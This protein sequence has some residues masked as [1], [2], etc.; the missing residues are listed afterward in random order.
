MSKIKVAIIML[1]CF[2]LL[3]QSS[4]I[5]DSKTKLFVNINSPSAV[6]MD[7]DTGRILYNKN[8]E[9]TRPMASLTK[10]MTSIMLVENCKM[11]EMIEVP[12]GAAW[13]GGSTVG[14]KKGDKISAES[15]LYGM[16]LPSGNDCAY[17]VG[18]HIGGSIENYGVMATKKAHEIGAINTNIANPHGLDDPNHYSTAYDMALITRYALKNQYIN[19]TV[20]TK[21]KTVNFG[22]FSKNLN[23]TN[24]LLRTYE[25]ADGV[26]TGFTNGA[27]RCLIA[28]ATKDNARYI[29]VVLGAETTKIRFKDAKTLLE[30]CFNRYEQKDISP[31]L[32]FYI[33]IPVYKGN[34]ATY[35][36]KIQDNMIIP[37]TDEEYEKI[38]IKQELITELKPPMKK[39][40]KI[41]NIYA[42]IGDEKIYEKGIFLEE[43]ITKKTVFDYFIDGIKN[44][45]VPTG[46]TL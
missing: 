18:E 21:N 30:E 31:L 44:M 32:K 13:M 38:Y 28:S 6:V 3:K 11:D 12:K 39:G 40:E 14:L 5:A 16:L 35:E 7:N 22:S 33:N 10:V 43:D 41:G 17:T 8:A 24:A 9:E 26:K 23:N 20:S 25:Y 4:I 29:A 45:F 2:F 46:L 19:E 34:I 1:I 36:R 27:N 37:L 15:L 42:Y